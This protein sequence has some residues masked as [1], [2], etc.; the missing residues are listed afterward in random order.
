MNDLCFCRAIRWMPVITIVTVVIWSY[1]AFIFEFCIFT[2][3]LNYQSIIFIIVYHVL[4]VMF[5]WTYIQTIR[6]NI[7]NVPCKFKVSEN[8]HERL[9]NC[10]TQEAFCNMLEELAVGLPL[11]TRTSTGAMRYCEKCCNIKPDRA[12]HCSVCATC[13]LKM[14]HHCPWVNNCVGF[15]NYKYFILFLTYSMLYCL[16]ITL[17]TVRYFLTYCLDQM[18]DRINFHVV[19]VFFVALLFVVSLISLFSYHCFLILHNRSTLE[20]FRA[21]VFKNGKDKNGFNIGK[22][23]NFKEV[24]GNQRNLWL[25]PI[26]SSQGDGVT[27]PVPSPSSINSYK[28]LDS[29]HVR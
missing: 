2:L 1:Y 9:M 8:N 25:F 29:T 14:D 18:D 3:E 21:P 28:S 22:C 26:P 17:C 11:L 12:H 15:T 7:G 27:F 20:A 19:F 13:V 23:N 4:V 24:F 6:T 5:F 10:E 16:F